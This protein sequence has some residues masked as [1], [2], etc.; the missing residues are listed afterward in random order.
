MTTELNAPPAMA[1]RAQVQAV[2]ASCPECP[3]FGLLVTW[4][5]KGAL[6]EC[7][8][9]GRWWYRELEHLPEFQNP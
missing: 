2:P 8:K 1:K 5:K 4:D 6:V 7:H 9:C 3:S